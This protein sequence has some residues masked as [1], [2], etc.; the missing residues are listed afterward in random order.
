MPMEMA[1]TD[2]D[3][4]LARMKKLEGQNRFWRRAGSLIALALGLSLTANVIAQEKPEKLLLQAVTIEA[5][6]FILKDASGT[7]RGRMTV[8]YGE[9]KL[10]LYDEAGKV[11]WSTGLRPLLSQR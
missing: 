10:E 6:T 5:R 8:E 3:E 2:F 1:H 11:T 4:L 9:A 7:V